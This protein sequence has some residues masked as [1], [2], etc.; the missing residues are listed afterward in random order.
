[1]TQWTPCPEFVALR[2]TVDPALVSELTSIYD[3]ISPLNS[4]PQMSD[5][6]WTRMNKALP[7]GRRTATQTQQIQKPALQHSR[8]TNEQ[9]DLPFV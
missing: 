4:N 1:M 6:T 7:E 8:E 3:G 2:T 5:G 9:N